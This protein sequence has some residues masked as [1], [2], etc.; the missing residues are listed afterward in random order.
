FTVSVRSSV[1]FDACVVGSGPGGVFAAYGLRG[2]KILML[3]VG[4]EPPAEPSAL[5]DSF[6]ELRH[7][8][9]NLERELLGEHLEGLAHLFVPSPSL[10]LKAPR[11]AFVIAESGR[12]TPVHSVSFKAAISLAQGGLANAW[13]AGVYRFNDR[14]LEGFPIRAID[15]APYYDSL[16]SHIGISG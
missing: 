3:D 1:V 16:A 13:G 10:K 9:S 7:T 2:C 12:L 14:D 11:P 6:Y 5:D 4:L 15:L 8:R